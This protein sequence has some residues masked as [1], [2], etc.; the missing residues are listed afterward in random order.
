M[1]GLGNPAPGVVEIV[2][3]HQRIGRLEL[4]E[5]EHRLPGGIDGFTGGGVD[6]LRTAV[7]HTRMAWPLKLGS[8]EGEEFLLIA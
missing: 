7:R 5:G 6:H 4:I 1:G 3:A 2:L 8:A